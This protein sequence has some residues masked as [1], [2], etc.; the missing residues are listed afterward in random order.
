MACTILSGFCVHLIWLYLT[1][2]NLSPVNP[3]IVIPVIPGLLVINTQHM[4]ELV[5]D[6][7]NGTPITNGHV[8][9]RSKSYM[10]TTPET[11]TNCT[12]YP[13]KYWIYS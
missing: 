1:S 2:L 4:H 12:M 8:V 9:I 10:S 11:E 6:V 13:N 5:H 7:S 3:N